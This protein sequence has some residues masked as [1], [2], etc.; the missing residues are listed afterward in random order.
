MKTR[1][2]ITLIVGIITVSISGIIIFGSIPLMVASNAYSGLVISSTPDFVFEEDFAN[3]PE[4]KFFVEKYPNYT[5]NHSADFLGWKI[6]NYDADIGQN[7]IHL[8][9]KKSVLHQG[10]KVSAGCSVGSYNYA[11]NILDDDVMDS[12]KN[13]VCLEKPLKIHV[14][15]GG[16]EYV[17]I[18]QGAVV[19]GNESLD[20]KVITVV[21]GKNNTVTWVNEDDT[22]HTFVSDE[23]GDESWST[24]MM[25]PGDSSSVTF[26]DTGIFSY[27]GTPGPWITGTV[28][29]VPDNYDESPLPS[30]KDYDFENIRMSNAC[31]EKHSFCFGVFENGTQIMTQC[32]FPIHGCSPVYF[33]SYVEEE[34]EN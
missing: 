1:Y 9:V 7:V 32:D 21:L 15:R 6:I 10:I 26:N 29:V 25:K 18:L 19:E 4:V 24:G 2:K 34:N 31:S 28:V 27:H 16:C 14:C 12:L 3:I 8:S 13:D 22:A 23:G 11:L 33:D 17:T 5:T 20:P 30:S